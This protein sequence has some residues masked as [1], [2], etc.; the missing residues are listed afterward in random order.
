MILLYIAAFLVAMA[1]GGLI[2]FTV[3]KA[4]EG[5]VECFNDGNIVGGVLLILVL[6]LI[7]GVIIGVIGGTLS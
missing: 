5:I 6:I 3:G 2:V 7:I 4:G 1:L